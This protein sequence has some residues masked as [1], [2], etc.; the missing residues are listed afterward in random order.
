MCCF[1]NLMHQMV[2]YSEPSE[3]SK[4]GR[5]SAGGGAGTGCLSWDWLGLGPTGP[6]GDAV[7]RCAHERHLLDK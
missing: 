5:C 6:I 2:C 1:V 3:E 4:T 7:S